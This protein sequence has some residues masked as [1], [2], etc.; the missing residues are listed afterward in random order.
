M[1]TQ[2]HF[3]N[4]Q[5]HILTTLETAEKQICVAVAWFT[6]K[7]ILKMLEK[8]AEEGVKVELLLMDDEIN[9]GDYGL[10]FSGLL[11]KGG[12]VYWVSSD[13]EENLMHNKF[14]VIDHHTVISGSYN[15][16]NKAQRNRENITINSN[17]PELAKQ[18][19]EEF[20]FLKS[21]SQ[22]NPLPRTL[23]EAHE[24]ILRLRRAQ[25]PH[26]KPRPL[27]SE[28]ELK[29]MPN[30]YNLEKALAEPEKVFKLDLEQAELHELPESIGQLQ[31]LQWLNLDCNR[32][33]S[34]PESIGQLQ[35]LQWLYLDRNSFRSPPEGLWQLHNLLSLRLSENP[36]HS[37]SEKSIGQLQNLQNLYLFDTGLTSL[38]E[39]IGQLHNLQALDLARNKLTSLPK[40]I[41]Q[42]QNI[43]EL[44]LRE[45]ILSSL[46]ESIG[47]LHNL[48]KLNL[49]SNK[50]T[51]LPKSIG[52][53]HNL[54][55]L[56]LR[57]NEEL[58]FDTVFKQL[59]HLQSLRELK[60]ANSKLTSLPESIGQ[61]HS[62]QTLDMRIY[63]LT[64]LPESI[65]QLQSLKE[66]DFCH[67][68]VYKNR[69]AWLIKSGIIVLEDH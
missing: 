57:W 32:L 39:S 66:I 41:G 17:H 25:K 11:A 69:P 18:F 30:Y 44:K 7:K 48:Q 43:Q 51:S 36:L 62:L 46:P 61:L 3:E 40:S 13:E 12:S 63:N 21:E 16:S 28:E 50:L 29:E 53:W 15:W 1:K 52:Q 38:P 22:G 56:N 35:N 42:L 27:L 10:D 34:L 4:I 5:S 9:R 68:P 20:V 2:A 45:N 55:K 49:R 14:A 64:S 58:D 37:L 31:N 47:Q 65:G 33:S 59:A 54:Q 23:E 6:D 19:L 26:I 60:L 67:S 8:K 24:E